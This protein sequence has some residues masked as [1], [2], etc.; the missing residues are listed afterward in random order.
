M[1]DFFVIPQF[2]ACPDHTCGC[3]AE[4]TDRFDLSSTDGLI[5]HVETYCVRCHIFRLPASRVGPA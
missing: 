1:P 4:I 3:L 2:V 5:S